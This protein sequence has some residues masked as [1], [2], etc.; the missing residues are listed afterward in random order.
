MGTRSVL[1]LGLTTRDTAD[2]VLSVDM[3]CVLGFGAYSWAHGHGTVL[4]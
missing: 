1:R 4:T 3:I 2:A